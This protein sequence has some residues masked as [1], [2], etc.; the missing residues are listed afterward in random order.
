MGALR[1]V[2]LLHS[3]PTLRATRYF[4]IRN[5]LVPS[6]NLTP[7]TGE[8]SLTCIT[9]WIGFLVKMH[10]AILPDSTPP[11]P[12]KLVPKGITTRRLQIN[13]SFR[14]KVTHSA[15][16]PSLISR[17]SGTTSSSLQ[18]LR[19]PKGEGCNQRLLGVA[20]DN[21]FNT[22]VSDISCLFAAFYRFRLKHTSSL[23]RTNV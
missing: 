9:R 8:I 3:T 5:V 2:F 14:T 4:E 19:F 13:S 17:P 20:G 21:E 6:L 16:S 7:P 18:C 10:S 12:P 11:P 1:V 23:Q 15:E 22:P